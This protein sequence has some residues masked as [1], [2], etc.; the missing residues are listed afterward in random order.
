VLTALVLFLIIRRTNA[1]LTELG[2]ART[3]GRGGR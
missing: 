1:R 3:I 2:I